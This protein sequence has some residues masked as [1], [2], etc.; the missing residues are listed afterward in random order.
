M[1]PI[2]FRLPEWLGHFPVR[3]FSM[4]VLIGVLL[5]GRWA[6]K[7]F[8]QI[9]IEKDGALDEFVFWVLITGFVGARLTYVAVHPDV[10][11]NIVSLVAVWEGG[12][13]SYGGFFGGAIG[14]WFF[15]RKHGVPFARLADVGLPALSL[16]QIFGRIGCLLVGDDHGRPWDGPWS[17]TF[18]GKPE[19]LIPPELVGVPL[20][21]S[22]IYLSLM[23]VV[24]FSAAL[25]VW[26]RRRFDGQVAGVTMLLYALG[27]FLVEFTRGDDRARGIYGAFSTA[28]WWSLVT[29][30][31]AVLL[32]L[33]MRRR[34]ESQPA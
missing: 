4:M 34:S 15:A 30:G 22:Q 27:R 17:V 9:G 24:I 21:P 2:L 6:G 31:L 23:N 25:W 33:F 8:K 26:K 7:R 11:R 28:Q 1:Y 18:T 13:V 5:A 19:S 10:Y 12:I 3:S 14:G 16:G 32:L 29:A 20:H